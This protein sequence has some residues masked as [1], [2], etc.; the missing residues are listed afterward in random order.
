VTSIRHLNWVL[1]WS[2]KNLNHHHR[3]GPANETDEHTQQHTGS[4]LP[5]REGDPPQ[6]L[7]EAP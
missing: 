6:Q 1:T 7:E 2:R 4:P 5:L 3:Q